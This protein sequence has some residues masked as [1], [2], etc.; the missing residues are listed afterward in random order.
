MGRAVGAP[1][2]QGIAI[3]LL[4]APRIMPITS[5]IRN[6]VV[7]TRSAHRV[8]KKRSLDMRAAVTCARLRQPREPGG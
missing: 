1:R 6:R 3:A 4:A 5:R 8:P 2:F 7:T